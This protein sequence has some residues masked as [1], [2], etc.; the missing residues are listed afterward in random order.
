MVRGTSVFEQLQL[1][2]GLSDV[3]FL[4]K[5][6]GAPEMNMMEKEGVIAALPCCRP[7][8]APWAKAQKLLDPLHESESCPSQEGQSC[9]QHMLQTDAVTE[10][11]FAPMQGVGW[12][13]R[14]SSRSRRRRSNGRCN[15]KGSMTSILECIEA[16]RL[17]IAK[18]LSVFTS[19]VKATSRETGRIPP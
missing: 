13:S 18:L 14:G 10:N 4:K 2:P 7:H 17:C 19:P 12:F 5:V 8:Q 9:T 11:G 1:W 16:H 3:C 15:K 6:S